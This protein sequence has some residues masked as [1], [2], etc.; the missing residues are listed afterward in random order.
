MFTQ[1]SS[2]NPSRPILHADWR[3]HATALCRKQLLYPFSHFLAVTRSRYCIEATSVQLTGTFRY[4]LATHKH[5]TKIEIFILLAR[6]F[7]K[8]NHLYSHHKVI[9]Q[10]RI[11]YFEQLSKYLS[12]HL[13]IS[14]YLQVNDYEI[15]V[16]FFHISQNLTWYSAIVPKFT[17]IYPVCS[18]Y[19]LTKQ[20]M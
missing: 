17:R 2:D 4:Y 1:E 12:S 19:E 14:T 18:T 6:I 3:F 8:Q 9:Q 20:F 16:K 7:R 15:V 5:E 13:I 11:I 10:V